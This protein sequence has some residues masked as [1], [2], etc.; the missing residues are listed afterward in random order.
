MVAAERQILEISDSR[1][2]EVE[3]GKLRIPQKKDKRC[4]G[5]LCLRRVL[6]TR[7]IDFISIK[8][9]LH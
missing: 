9:T 8:P 7:G 4:L 5:Q 3:L 6:D 2:L 1:S